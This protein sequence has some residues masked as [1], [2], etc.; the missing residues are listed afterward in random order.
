MLDFAGDVEWLANS[1]GSVTVTSTKITSLGS[2]RSLSRLTWRSLSLYSAR[3]R[4]SGSL[5]TNL[6]VRRRSVADEDL[7]G[8]VEG[9]LGDPQFE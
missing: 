6:M 8:L 7:R 3:S 4:L 5:A 2:G 1:D 9:D